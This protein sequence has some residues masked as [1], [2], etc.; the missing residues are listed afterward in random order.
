MEGFGKSP[1]AEPMK[2]GERWLALLGDEY[3]AMRD[4]PTG[5]AYD[6]DNKPVLMRD[7]DELCADFAGPMFAALENAPKGH[8]DH[9]RYLAEARDSF[10]RHFG[11]PQE[12]E[13]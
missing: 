3:L 2:R 10:H 7:F 11:Q 1:E 6:D 13:G 9:E 4:I 12:S 5:N 8:P